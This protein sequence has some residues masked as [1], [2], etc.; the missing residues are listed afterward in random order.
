MNQNPAYGSQTHQQPW[1]YTYARHAVL[2]SNNLLIC[3]II[4]QQ[5]L[6]SFQAYGLAWPGLATSF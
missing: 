4:V 6:R 2:D 3:F 5:C 1:L